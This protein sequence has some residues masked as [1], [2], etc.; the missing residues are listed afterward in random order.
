[1]VIF[2]RIFEIKCSH[3]IV[4]IFDIVHDVE[5]LHG[6]HHLEI[7]SDIFTGIAHISENISKCC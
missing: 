5:A 2:F 7:F 6:K 3:F 1:M 4:A